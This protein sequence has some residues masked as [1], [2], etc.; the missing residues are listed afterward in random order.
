MNVQITRIFR[1]KMAIFKTALSKKYYYDHVSR[2]ELYSSSRKIKIKSN[3]YNDTRK[4]SFAYLIDVLFI[5][6]DH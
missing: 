2:L 5:L 3:S 1:R 4:L 6:H